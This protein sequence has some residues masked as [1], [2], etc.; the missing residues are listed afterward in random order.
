MRKVLRDVFFLLFSSTSHDSHMRNGQKSVLLAEKEYFLVIKLANLK[1]SQK[2]E[3]KK[4]FLRS[5]NSQN[6]F[7]ASFSSFFCDSTVK[8]NLSNV[9]NRKK[10]TQLFI[11]LSP[12]SNQIYVLMKITF[13][14]EK[15]PLE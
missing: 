9:F 7:L 3:R 2:L 10:L 6:F 1:H 8:K 11:L 15:S 12:S 5:P 4:F 13:H 14:F